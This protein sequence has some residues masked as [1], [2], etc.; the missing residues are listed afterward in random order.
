MKDFE[1]TR[2]PY[3]VPQ[4]VCVLLCPEEVLLSLSDQTGGI[5][6]VDETGWGNF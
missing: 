1:F 3:T 5:D 4:T 2:K 6:P